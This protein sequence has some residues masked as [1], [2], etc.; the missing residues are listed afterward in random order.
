[1]ESPTKKEKV[2]PE[3]RALLRCEQGSGG[4]VVWV[5]ELG[6][7]DGCCWSPQLALLTAEVF[8]FFGEHLLNQFW[9]VQ[10]LHFVHWSSLLRLL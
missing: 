4:S 7:G 6:K 8:A 1:M 9:T 3:H 10:W 5:N 2:F